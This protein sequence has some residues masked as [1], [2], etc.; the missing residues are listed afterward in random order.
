MRIARD[1]TTP[2]METRAIPVPAHVQTFSLMKFMAYLL[3]SVGAATSSP[4][5]MMMVRLVPTDTS[6]PS[7]M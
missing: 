5:V 4:V 7:G 1:C 3:R 6:E 2:D